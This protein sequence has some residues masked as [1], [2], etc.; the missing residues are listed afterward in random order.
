V[1]A[2]ENKQLM[3]DIFAEMAKGNGKLFVDSMADDFRWTIAG[4]TKWSRTYEGKQTV[5]SKLLRPLFSQFADTYTATANRFIAEGDYVVVEFRGRATTKAG[6]PYN[7][8]Y[9]CIY[10]IADGKLQ[11]LTEYLDTELVTAVL[12]DPD[13]NLL[14]I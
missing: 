2:A 14:P 9:C 7:N 13:Q 12:Q 5:L 10:R 3:Q 4:A 1:G 11:E 8:N 6:K